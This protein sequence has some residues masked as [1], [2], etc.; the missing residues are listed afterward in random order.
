LDACFVVRDLNGQQ[1]A[2]AYF[3][4]EPAAKIGGKIIGAGRRETDH[5]SSVD[6]G[7]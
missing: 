4:D 5:V 6:S 2:Y 1:L 3:E 7:A